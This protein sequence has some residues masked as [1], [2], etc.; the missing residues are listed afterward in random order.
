[1]RDATERDLRKDEFKN[2]KLED[3]EVREDG[4]VV[5]KDRFI[6]AVSKIA[7]IVGATDRGNFEIPD[8]IEKVR[9]IT[10][11]LTDKHKAYMLYILAREAKNGTLEEDVFIGDAMELALE[12]KHWETA[13][14]L[15][16]ID[17]QIEIELDRIFEEEFGR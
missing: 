6:S 14:E 13:K 1:M 2:A 15:Y 9:G 5:R 16:L 11:G 8:V 3:Y 4:A 17:P 10:E 12:P 7:N